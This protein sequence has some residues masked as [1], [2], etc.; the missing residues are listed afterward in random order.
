MRTGLRPTALLPLLDGR[1]MIGCF[2]L[3][4][5]T[6]AVSLA[7][8]NVGGFVAAADA[9]TLRLSIGRVGATE[10]EQQECYFAFGFG[11]NSAYVIFPPKATG[12]AIMRAQIG[13]TGSLLFAP[14][15]P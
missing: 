4:L 15:V 3:T 11:P 13:K 7:L 14:D 10:Q 5:R 1:P 12:C 6:I 2:R 9:P 8:L